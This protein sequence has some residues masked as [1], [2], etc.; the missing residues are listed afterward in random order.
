MKRLLLATLF[1]ST[2][3]SACGGG[4]NS[5][6]STTE[7]SKADV[8]TAIAPKTASITPLPPAPEVQ[9]AK[10][11]ISGV[12]ANTN[13]VRDDIEISLAKTALHDGGTASSADF[14]KLLEV[15]K[16]IQPSETT[17]TIDIK[18][19]YCSYQSM[20]ASIKD[21]ISASMMIALVTDTPARKRAYA[22]QSINTS[23][24]LG[25]ESCE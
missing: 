3:L 10:S 22:E 1:C 12:D 18:K 20:P 2:A 5:S 24:S 6:T 21:K 8:L 17:K 14:S 15:V 11:S 16:I 19:F 9:A 25:A 23:G 7:A 13:G 4:S